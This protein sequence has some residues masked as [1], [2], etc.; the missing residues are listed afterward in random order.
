MVGPPRS[1]LTASHT[2]AFSTLPQ[3]GGT[4][5]QDILSRRKDSSA[6]GPCSPSEFARPDSSLPFSHNSSEKRKAEEDMLGEESSLITLGTQK[7]QS[8]RR[9]EL[10][11]WNQG[12]DIMY[13][14]KELPRSHLMPH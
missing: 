14:L 7:L 3:I 10:T 5:I 6:G 8:E 13:P 9:K 11:V 1:L 12:S 2:L 4:V